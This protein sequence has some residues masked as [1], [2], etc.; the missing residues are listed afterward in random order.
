MRQCRQHRGRPQSAADHILAAQRFDQGERGREGGVG[1]E[2]RGVEPERVLGLAQGRGA[3]S[4]VDLS[5]PHHRACE[6][7]SI[8]ASRSSPSRVCEEIE[9]GL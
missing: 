8:Y 3:T 4:R 1:A 5:E 6:T 7:G 9:G 2:R